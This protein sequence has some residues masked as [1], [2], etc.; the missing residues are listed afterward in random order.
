MIRYIDIKRCG[1]ERTMELREKKGVH[2]LVFP[3]IEELGIVDHLFSTRLG[4]VSKGYF[5][6][7][8]LSYTRGDEKEAVDENY[9]RISDVLGHGRKLDDFVCTF[10]TH[11]VNVMKVTEEDRGKGPAKLRDYTDIDGLITNIPGIILST[12]HADCPPVFFIDP[13]KK[14]IGLSHS[15]WKGTK[16]EIAART[17][18]AMTK[19]YGTNPKDL[20]CAVGPSICGECYEIGADVAKEF[21]ENYTK[22]ELENEKI[23]VP[24]PNDKFRLYLW[25]AIRYTLKKS[26]VKPE[27][28]LVTDICTRCNPDLLFSHRVHKDNRGNLCAFLSLKDDK[29]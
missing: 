7:M 29:E 9:R 8:N 18:E 15:G 16:G 1:S 21:S 5:S 17:I 13:V 26:G 24:Y 3:K 12:F 4:G 25:N 11:T 20:I 27:N 10:Q 2:Y 28:I 14:A 23:I 22:E 6:E 19:E